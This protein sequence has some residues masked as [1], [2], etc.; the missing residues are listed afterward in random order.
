MLTTQV[1]LAQPTPNND[2]SMGTP[3]NIESVLADRIKHASHKHRAGQLDHRHIDFTALT[4]LAVTLRSSVEDVHCDQVDRSAIA[5]LIWAIGLPL[6]QLGDVQ[7]IHESPVVAPADDIPADATVSIDLRTGTVRIDW[8][9]QFPEIRQSP[10][11]PLRAG[12]ISTKPLP[13]WLAQWLRTHTEKCT[14]TNQGPR[15]C[16]LRELLPLLSVLSPYDPVVTGRDSTR[17]ITPSFARLAN[18]PGPFARQLGIDGLCSAL[19]SLD[20]SQTPRSKVYYSCV[21]GTE[22]WDAAR[23]LF[24][25]ISWGDLVAMP[26]DTPAFGTSAANDEKEIKGFIR[27]VQLWIQA[28]AVSKRCSL[29]ALLEFHN[30][31]ACALTWWISF[32]IASRR[33]AEVNWTLAQLLAPAIVLDD[34]HIGEI[35]GALPAPVCPLIQEQIGL[36]LRHL[37]AL[38]QRLQKYPDRQV[39]QTREWLKRLFMGDSVPLLMHLQAR[40]APRLIGSSDALQMVPQGNEISPDAGRKYWEN[41]LRKVRIPTTLID[42]VQRHEV[43]GQERF[44]VAADFSL[45]T[46]FARVAH[47]MHAQLQSLTGTTFKGL[48]TSGFS[49]REALHGS[50][51]TAH[52][53]PHDRTK[54]CPSGLQLTVERMKKAGIHVAVDELGNHLL[55]L[56]PITI[57]R[58]NR[59]SLLQ[60]WV[61]DNCAEATIQLTLLLVTWDGVTGTQNLVDALNACKETYQHPEGPSIEW[62]HA[63]NQV[64]ERRILSDFT[65]LTLVECRRIGWPDDVHLVIDAMRSVLINTGLYSEPG[66]VISELWFDAHCWH[67]LHL[68]MPL[69]AHLNGLLVLTALDRSSWA[70]Y[71]TQKNERPELV[72]PDADGFEFNTTLAD[73]FDSAALDRSSSNRADDA[74]VHAIMQCMGRTRQ[75]GRAVIDATQ[76]KLWL[77]QLQGCIPMATQAGHRACVVLGWVVDLVQNGTR[78][79]LDAAA[80]TV[81]RYIGSILKSLWHE[82]HGF[83]EH[84][85]DAESRSYAELYHRV[86]YASPSSSAAVT[87]TALMH[88][89]GYL[90]EYFGAPALSQVLLPELPAPAVNAQAI[91]PHEQ[92]RA[93]DLLEGATGDERLLKGTRVLM[94][95]ACGGPF[96]SGEIVRLRLCNLIPNLSRNGRCISVDIEIAPS[97]RHGRLKS[98]AAQRVVHIERS[99]SVEI[100]CSWLERRK[101]LEHGMSD[102]LLFGDPASGAPYRRHAML[103][104]ANWVLKCVTGRPSISM[105]ALRH[106]FISK[107]CDEIFRS[108]ATGSISRLALLATAAGHASEVTTLVSYTHQHEAG[109]R[110]WL[111]ANLRDTINWS[112]ERMGHLLACHSDTLRQRASRQGISFSQLSWKLLQQH[113]SAFK[114]VF[115]P[116]D[117]Q[118]RLSSYAPPD[119]RQAHVAFDCRRVMQVLLEFFSGMSLQAVASRHLLDGDRVME[120]ETHASE[121]LLC[122]HE[123]S[124]GSEGKLQSS[125]LHDHKRRWHEAFQRA[126]Q[127]KYKAFDK[128]LTL[129]VK[130]AQTHAA[131][132]AWQ[133]MFCHGYI[134]LEDLNSTNQ[135]L[136]FLR[137]CE[138][139]PRALRI[140]SSLH[141]THLTP[142]LRIW[143]AALGEEPNVHQVCSRPGR[144]KAYLLW[145]SAPQDASAKSAAAEIKGFCAWMFALH[146]WA[147][148]SS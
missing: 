103:H 121:L 7:L 76:R 29:P 110:L 97:Q 91:W 24:H 1:L 142:L 82:L 44:C 88:W 32:A 35:Q 59:F 114:N 148:S 146:V 136:T 49:A 13:K 126:G 5:A 60:Q 69:A 9:H 70:R 83:N 108:S 43:Q 105:H 75:E 16:S 141:Q 8:R 127:N 48:A 19:L 119:L 20:F 87:R 36:Y 134:S 112:S 41:H 77:A 139:D 138:V 3:R 106:S 66:D 50:L 109:L 4:R 11:A 51:P 94:A 34:K 33:V 18:S 64:L 39:Q 107:H 115:P 46:S 101:L 125:R 53:P 62:I 120:I 31:Y 38:G 96:R 111:D 140:G 15:P 81:L 118:M 99:H 28:A 113:A 78:S 58:A 92:Q 68:P 26:I 2:E 116:V 17:S 129:Q 100:I 145:T 61:V 10:V 52:E 124:P 135:L 95:I 74:I 117:D 131:V 67:L 144:P 71:S 22:I 73:V 93:F 6:G 133:L 137:T 57:Q 47:V 132:N 55:R 98:A 63:E 86:L 143:R 25:E 37:H 89:H 54:K 130:A 80:S 30:R 147:R 128:Y 12:Q 104:L 102:D 27:S 90:M 23:Q 21:P 123:K 122:L 85:A 56:D 42:A 84:W 45:T 40:R 14:S 72:F 65:V 79:K